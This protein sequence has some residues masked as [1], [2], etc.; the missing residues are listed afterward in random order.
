MIATV[1]Q[2]PGGKR[3]AKLDGP[4]PA[5]LKEVL[6]AAGVETKPGEKAEYSV[7]GEDV[8]NLD[9]EVPDGSVVTKTTVRVEGGQ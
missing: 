3:E 4:G 5:P 1:A 2:Y 8:A 7:N 6:A 9:A